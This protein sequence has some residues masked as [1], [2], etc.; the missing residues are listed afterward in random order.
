MNGPSEESPIT[1][2]GSGLDHTSPIQHAHPGY[3]SERRGS[4]EIST[5]L[6]GFSFGTCP[7]ALASTP[8]AELGPFDYPV[9]G[10]RF[11]ADAKEGIGRRD[12][13]PGYPDRRGSNDITYGNSAHPHSPFSSSGE[14][15]HRAGSGS[16]SS[17]RSSM[18]ISQLPPLAY[19]R[20]EDYPRLEYPRTHP[21][22]NPNRRQSLALGQT[23]R[24]ASI[25]SREDLGGS[26]MAAI[27]PSVSVPSSPLSGQ[28]QTL[29]QR[30]GALDGMKDHASTPLTISRPP[31]TKAYQSG[32]SDTSTIGPGTTITPYDLA[33]RRTSTCSTIT[34]LP[35][36][37]RRPSILHSASTNS[38]FPPI[39]SPD[40][41]T[42]NTHPA[43]PHTFPFPPKGPMFASNGLAGRRSSLL[44]PQ[45]AQNVPIPPSLLAR[46]GSLPPPPD[47]ARIQRLSL[48]AQGKVSN[49][50]EDSSTNGIGSAPYANFGGY[51]YTTA[52][53]YRR[54]STLS[55]P[56]EGYAPRGSVDVE[57]IKEDYS[58]GLG[59]GQGEFGVSQ[60]A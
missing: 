24:R 46:R 39:L 9:G 11:S 53:L 4:E 18:T 5:S 13:R 12:S 38:A 45:K 20:S 1:S 26:R 49:R 2:T 44:F 37:G 23:Y 15:Y 40:L 50:A 58:P 19:D 16:Q 57:T 34:T 55:N 54:A 3:H 33:S 21:N 36:E 48:S 35:A 32:D 29:G 52:Q 7:S 31:L 60:A 25:I 8:T 27:S 6:A 42:S 59:L 14:R 30:E 28:K 47:H 43:A 51:G 41:T 10:R 17:S 56:P 22:H